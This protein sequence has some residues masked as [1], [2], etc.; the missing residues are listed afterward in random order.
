MQ[1]RIAPA[2]SKRTWVMRR[3]GEASDWKAVL[4]QHVVGHGFIK[5]ADSILLAS[6]TTLIGLMEQIVK[7]QREKVEAWDLDILTSNLQVL[8]E[9]RDAQKETAMIF[10]DT[11]ITL[12]GGEYSPSLDALFGP[13]VI[14]AVTA[15]DCCLDVVF[16]G[17]KTVSFEN[18]L[19]LYYQFQHELPTQEAYAT[20][21]THTR[22]LLIDHSK[23]GK[24]AKRRANVSIDD[25]LQNAQ[26]CY[27][28]ST[29]DPH[30][31]EAIVRIEREEAYLR[32]QLV[33]LARKKTI[34]REKDFIFRLIRHDGTVERELR[35]SHFWG[36]S[37]TTSSIA[38]T[39]QG[40]LNGVPRDEELRDENHSADAAA[41][42][43]RA[44]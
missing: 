2:N 6:G 5:Y 1:K 43:A 29:Y 36:A 39:R 19:G 40:Y 25:L 38:A 8:Y 15:K 3:A 31:D 11:Q 32:A 30:D 20:C 26:S 4:N 18:Q 23:I 10:G 21:S 28:I 22:V 33:D 34:P 42:S 27:I 44:S 41:L 12:T 14:A 16:F 17:A 35:L 9:I 24:K 7:A 13:A 37:D